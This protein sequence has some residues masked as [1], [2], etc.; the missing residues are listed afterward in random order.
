MAY[1]TVE[2][3]RCKCG[4]CLAKPVESSLLARLNALR[5]AY[6][7]PLYITSGWRCEDYNRKVGGDKE[8][9]HLTGHAADIFCTS[10][11]DR[12][13]LLFHTMGLFRR[14]GIGKTFL[15]VDTDI[16][17][18]QEVIWLYENH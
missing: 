10:S 13:K 2:E 7:H 3:F 1:F 11:M 16:N 9:A 6:G 8:S 5:S 14:V 15:H 12:Y 17:K 18:P 4:Q